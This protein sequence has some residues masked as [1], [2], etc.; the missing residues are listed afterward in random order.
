MNAQQT[1]FALAWVHAKAGKRVRLS[2][3]R[4]RW[5]VKIFTTKA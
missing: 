5:I 4:G 1:A 2:K 3:E